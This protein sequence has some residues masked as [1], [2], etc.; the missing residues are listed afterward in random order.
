MKLLKYLDPCFS[1]NREH[2]VLLFTV[3]VIPSGITV[4]TVKDKG[5][6]FRILL[7]LFHVSVPCI[8]YRH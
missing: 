8:S 3:F 1:M 7:V 2:F 6:L 4:R 5:V